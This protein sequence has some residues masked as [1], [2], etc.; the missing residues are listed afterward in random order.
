L[1]ATVYCMT[2]AFKNKPC[3]LSSVFA[4]T[5]VDTFGVNISGGGRAW[6]PLI[7]AGNGQWRP[8]LTWLDRME[9]HAFISRAR[10]VEGLKIATIVFAE[11]LGNLQHS[12]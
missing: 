4:N 1:A 8:E 9:N 3:S 5:A 10:Y 12:T 6:K 7:R 2:S 11:T